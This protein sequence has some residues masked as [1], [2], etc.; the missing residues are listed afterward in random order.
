MRFRWIFAAALAWPAIMPVQ[1][2]WAQTRPAAAAIPAQVRA[3]GDALLLDQTLAVMQQEAIANARE[4]AMDLFGVD[5][6][7]AWNAA[8]RD[9]FDPAAARA[10]FDLAASDAAGMIAPADHAAALEFYRSPLGTRLLDLELSARA[11]MIDKD[12]E[13]A[14]TESWDALQ[15]DLLPAS[16]TRAGLIRQI[17]ASNDLID[18]NVASALNGNL[19]FYQGMAEGG[20][21]DMGSEG[22]IAEVWS[23]EPQL[24]SDTEN[25][26]YPF[27]N[28]AYAPLTD[29]QLQDYIAFSKSSAGQALNRVLFTAFDALGAQQSRGMGLAAGR[30]ML[31]QDI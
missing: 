16:A 20:M 18:S 8:V 19:A 5:D 24:R 27:L 15:A 22:T 12:I 23:Q 11:Q 25:W 28:L 17:V 7:P 1:A 29:A 4:T 10:A 14:A 31:G 30:L 2:V 6:L 13:A 3:L 21:A 9:L 26:L